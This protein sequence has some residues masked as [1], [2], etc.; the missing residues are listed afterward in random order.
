MKDGGFVTHPT[1][2]GFDYFSLLSEY[3][4]PLKRQKAVD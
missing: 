4:S 2:R 1:Y 3:Q